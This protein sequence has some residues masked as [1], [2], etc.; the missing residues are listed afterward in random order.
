MH[1]AKRIKLDLAA[2]KMSV[3]EPVVD[4]TLESRSMLV[5]GVESMKKMKTASVLLS[6]LGALGVEI[7]ESGD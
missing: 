4:E 5:Y 2:D 1:Q 6:G 3:D 7:G